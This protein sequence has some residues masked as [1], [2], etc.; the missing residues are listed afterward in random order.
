MRILQVIP[1]FSPQMG[2]SPQVAYQI[3]RHLAQR[4]HEVTLVT[5]D[6]AIQASRFQPDHFDVVFFPNLIAKDGMYLGPGLIRW[7]KENTRKFD[8]IHM[9]EFR[10][11]QNAVMRHFAIQSDVPY[12]LSAH[13]TLP[14][15]IQ[16]KLFKKMYDLLIGNALLDSA[17]RLIAVSPVEIEHYQQAGV[18]AGR[19]RV[20]YNGL[21]VEEYAQLPARG[22]FRHNLG[23]ISENT[24]IILFL[25][26]L[27][28]IKG[29]N[30]LIEAF[31]QL[32]EGPPPCV[33]A[34]AGPD[35]GELDSLITL[36]NHLNVQD[37]VLFTGPLY[38]VDK[39]AA[40]ADADVFVLPSAYEIFGLVV[41]EALMCETPV[42][43]SED[44]GMGA[45]ISEAGA[46]F[47]TKYG[48]V[49]QMVDMLDFVLTHSE[50]AHE[51]AIKGKNW[52]EQRLN[53]KVIVGELEKV[54]QEASKN[55]SYPEFMLTTF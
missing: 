2:G 30:Y 5:S 20:V 32:K 18:N 11:F 39:L 9:H 41:F 16:R 54:Y 29:I 36:S 42:I 8:I 31:S 37:K 51:R 34:I 45:L 7:A 24:K 21:D 28:K 23:G 26:R 44:S 25:G 13:G 40:Y 14:V 35:E 55:S 19:I 49:G 43:V 50:D 10:T 52:V 48:D 6:Y 46:G 1:F 38:G 4:G 3:C 33:L 22:S 15:I 27:H 47:L 17:S 12:V 53:W